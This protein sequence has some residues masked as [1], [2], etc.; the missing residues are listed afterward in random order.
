MR[1]YEYSYYFGHSNT[2]YWYSGSGYYTVCT[3]QVDKKI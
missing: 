1:G 2:Y 3:L